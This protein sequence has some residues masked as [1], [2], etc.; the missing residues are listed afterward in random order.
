MITKLSQI[1]DEVKKN[2]KK[3]LVVAY[4]EDSHTLA[5]VSN[6]VD[7]GIVD[8]IL[9]GNP[10]IIKTV[11]KEH[12][13]DVNK[14]TIVEGKGDVD[15]VTKAVKM[16]NAGEADVLMKGL[17]STDKYM[18]GIL[19]KEYGLVPPKGVLSHVTLIE[20]PNYHKLL[21]VGDVAVIP[22]PD[23][24]QKIAIARNVISVAQKLGIAK[25]KVAAIAP[26]EQMLQ[27]IPSCVE[28]A[29]LA[30]MGDRGQLGNAF[31]DGPLALD[32]A[33][34][35]ETVK[36]KKLVSPVAGDA[37]CMVFP[38]LES[39][40]VFFKAC[41]KLGNAELAAMVV[42]TK[43]PCVLTSRGDSE[44]SKLYSI[45]LATLYAK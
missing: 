2:G 39:G 34:D 30:K 37:D 27:G 33:I 28:A 21:I 18:R 22:A 14:F 20:S 1:I 5:S 38:N 25:P 41:T 9:V 40:N 36:T 19:N 45:A 16:I 29:I 17:V 31:V 3:R 6:A 23:M 32:V 44:Q 24:N 43:S 35:P 15:C 26:T 10:D 8:A 4:A 7:C 12:S 11:C 13:I 42:G